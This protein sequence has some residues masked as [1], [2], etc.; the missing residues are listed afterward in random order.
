MENDGSS[1]EKAAVNLVGIGASA[2]GIE[3][4]G[5]FLSALSP[6]S[7]MAFLLVQH[8]DPGHPSLLAEIPSK[9][10]SI[11]IVDA[12]DGTEFVGDHF[13]IIPADA[14]VAAIDGVLRLHPFDSALERR[15]PIDSMFRALARSRGQ[16]SVGVVLSGTGSDGA[17][18]IQEI[19]GGG[20]NLCS[21]AQLGTIQGDAPESYR[22]RVRGLCAH[23]QRNSRKNLGDR[24][25]SVS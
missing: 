4:L 22:N 24:K 3:A 17:M 18:G 2:G 16:N 1:G 15:M 14:T 6:T 5:E 23:G 8:R 20:D 11:P 25:A 10:T 9:N 21:T 13:Y 7:G 19:K 12:Q